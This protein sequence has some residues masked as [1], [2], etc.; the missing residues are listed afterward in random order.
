MR[1]QNNND[2]KK[3]YIFALQTEGKAVFYTAIVLSIGVASW[4]FSPLKYLADMGLLLLYGAD[5][6]LV[7]DQARP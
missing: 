3:A 2:F 7:H 4:N 6:L 5:T 1:L